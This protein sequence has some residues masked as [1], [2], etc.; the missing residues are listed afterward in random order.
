L[1]NIVRYRKGLQLFGGCSGY[2]CGAAFNFITVLPDG[3]AHACRKFPSPIG[4]VVHS[5]IAEVYNSEAA[6]SYRTGCDVCRSCAI[7]HVCGGCLASAYS[8]G[9]NPLKERDPYCFIER[10]DT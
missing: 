8:F 3:E 7:R 10:T 9:L 6:R 2:G 1:I 4:D 5:S